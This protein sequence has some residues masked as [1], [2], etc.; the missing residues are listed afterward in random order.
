MRAHK[1]V[2]LQLQHRTPSPDSDADNT[3]LP[4]VLFRNTQ[5]A[6]PGGS[7]KAS[8][9]YLPT[10]GSPTKP[11]RN[12]EDDQWDDSEVPPA[13]S[14]PGDID[15]EQYPFLDPA[16]IHQCEM[17]D[18]VRTRRR[19]TT[20]SVSHSSH[21]TCYFFPYYVLQDYPMLDWM[22]QRDYFLAEILRHESRGDL[23]EAVCY[24][25]NL[26]FA[27]YRCLDCFGD[28]LLCCECTRSAHIFNPLHRIQACFL[29]LLN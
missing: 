5:L 23:N 29:F 9:S 19:R 10:L 25:C 15:V 20:A 6:S 14:H 21:L 3:P 4:T 1:C 27:L 12:R 17:D 22:P 8:T 28:Q 11:T 7:R 16:Y 13:P 26:R 24:R 2:K 18:P